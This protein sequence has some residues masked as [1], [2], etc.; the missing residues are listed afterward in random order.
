[1]GYSQLRKEIKA[2]TNIGKKQY[3]RLCTAFISKIDNEYM[4]ESLIKIEPVA[5]IIAKK[6]YSDDKK[7]HNLFLNQ[8]I[9]IK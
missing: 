4:N 1:M 9:H 3:Q 7:F 8:N 5:K 6:K 2:Q